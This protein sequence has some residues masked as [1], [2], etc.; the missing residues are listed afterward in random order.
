MK[1]NIQ[2]QKDVDMPSKFSGRFS[3]DSGLDFGPIIKQKLMIFIKENP[4]MPFELKP[5]YPESIRQRGWFEG[6]FVPLVTYYQEGK[7]YH[8]QKDLEEVREWLKLE[9]NGRFVT[10]QGIS[11]KV[12]QTTKH[13]LNN[14]FLDRCMDWFV[15]N[16]EPPFESLNPESY[17]N[18]R[19]TVYPYGGPDNYIDYLISLNLLSKNYVR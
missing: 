9:F 7:D 6:G 19:D 11:H 13:A 16:Y 14:G 8:N 5:L 3:K 15:E 17:K 18:W 10:I 12:A 2:K 1:L 4:G